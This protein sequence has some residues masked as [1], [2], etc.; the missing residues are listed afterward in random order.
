[1]KKRTKRLSLLLSAVLLLSLFAGCGKGEQASTGE[2]VP[3]F[4]AWIGS[5]T[6]DLDPALATSPMQQ[7][8][9]LA[10]YEGLM[11]LDGDENGNAKVVPGIARS[12]EI[13]ENFDGTISYVFTF[14]STAR[15]SD[16]KR[17][18]ADDF[19]FA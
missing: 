12:Y 6:V 11:K 15:W 7:S 13:T 1:M 16:G 3:P 4:R 17:V 19:V 5:E 14:R 2:N 9:I 10:L 18:K 8:V